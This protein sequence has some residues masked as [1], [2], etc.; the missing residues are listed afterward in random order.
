M[1]SLLIACLLMVGIQVCGSQLDGSNPDNNT[2]EYENLIMSH[3]FNDT[4][5]R[6]INGKKFLYYSAGPGGRNWSLYVPYI[7][8][9]IIMAGDSI[10][11]PS[12]FDT[13]F[14]RNRI[15]T[16][17]LDSLQSAPSRGL[18]VCKRTT[19]CPLTSRLVLF[20]PEKE[21]IFDY[22]DI[23]LFKGQDSASFTEH[24]QELWYFTLYFTLLREYQKKI[25]KPKS[26]R[27]L[28]DSFL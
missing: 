15:L 17:A 23:P 22:Y 9:Y 27:T 26:L 2:S 12:R 14:T 3:N 7:G 20:S 28:K 8:Y 1:K 10:G 24:Y 6:I 25:P 11:N 19:Y 13:I 4:V 5:L 21:T 16:W 18:L